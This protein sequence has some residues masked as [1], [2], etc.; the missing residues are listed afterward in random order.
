MAIKDGNEKLSSYFIEIA[1]A[2]LN[3]RDKN[4]KTALMYTCESG[5]HNLV[6]MLLQKKADPNI[7]DKVK[8]NFHFILFIRL[9]NFFFSF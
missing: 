2:D 6:G 9:I 5:H 3:F 8:L 4:G 1:D 7:L